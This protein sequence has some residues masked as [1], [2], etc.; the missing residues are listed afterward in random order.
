MRHI[1][2]GKIGQQLTRIGELGNS[3]EY[4]DYGCESP[5]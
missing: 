2:I 4:S 5:Y 3:D 1:L